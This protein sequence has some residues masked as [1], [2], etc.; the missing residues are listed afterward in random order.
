MTHTLALPSA[1]YE[2]GERRAGRT[3]GTRVP[4]CFFGSATQV[5]AELALPDLDLIARA[6]QAPS[7]RTRVALQPG[8]LLHGFRAL[9]WLA[10]RLG[11]LRGGLLA[12]SYVA[13]L[14]LRVLL[15]RRAR[16][17]VDLSVVVHAPS[18]VRRH[19]VSVPNG[20]AGTALATAA[21]VREL[22]PRR[23]PTG[24]V[25][26]GQLVAADVL[27]AGMRALGGP[28]AC[29]DVRYDEQQLAA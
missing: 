1:C 21:F 25:I 11:T 26:A 4:V 17:Q 24:V 10:D 12:A 2:G 16:S 3:V 6:T 20:A 29:L 5:A 15:P 19:L 23:L 28:D 27:L 18:G 9:A 13:L 22:V 7:V 8:S 14:A